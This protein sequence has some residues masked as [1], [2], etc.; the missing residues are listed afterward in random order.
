VRYV[1]VYLAA[2]RA[3]LYSYNCSI[4]TL[5]T[6]SLES[7]RV[8]VEPTTSPCRFSSEALS[9]V[10][11][12]NLL[13]AVVVPPMLL[14]VYHP[15]PA[16]KN[17]IGRQKGMFLALSHTRTRTQGYLDVHTLRALVQLCPCLFGCSI[18]L[19]TNVDHGLRRRQATLPCLDLRESQLES[20]NPAGL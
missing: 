3:N 12:T 11:F 4:C 10:L 20:R 5:K 18:S 9:A 15:Y 6:A 13:R 16:R 19:P 2:R 1:H 7:R 14:L 17:T 8:L